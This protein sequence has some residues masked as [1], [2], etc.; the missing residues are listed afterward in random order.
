M[1]SQHVVTNRHSFYNLKFTFSKT[2]FRKPSHTHPRLWY[3]LRA[4]T[5]LITSPLTLEHEEISPRT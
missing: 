3:M 5:H 4:E 1:F 2:H